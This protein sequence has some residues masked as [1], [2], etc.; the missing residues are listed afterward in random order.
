MLT[1]RLQLDFVDDV[2]IRD[3]FLILVTVSHKD[4]ISKDTIK[5]SKTVIL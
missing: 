5:N 3:C 1:V 2:I 4:N